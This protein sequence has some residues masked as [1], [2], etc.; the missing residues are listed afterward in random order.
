MLEGKG[1]RARGREKMKRKREDVL[2]GWTKL[3]RALVDLE[4]RETRWMRRSKVKGG[5]REDGLREAEGVEKIGAGKT[6]GRD[7]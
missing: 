4:E 6:K 2:D 5:K 7:K 1:G 3:L